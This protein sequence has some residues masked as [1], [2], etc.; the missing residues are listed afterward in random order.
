M[1]DRENSSAEVRKAASRKQLSV[2]LAPDIHEAL[3]RV[4]ARE[5]R[6]LSSAVNAM[7]AR[8]LAGR[9]ELSGA[10]A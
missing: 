8:E 3:S 6:T 1:T 4:A 7:L 5:R 10:A 2:S 9:G